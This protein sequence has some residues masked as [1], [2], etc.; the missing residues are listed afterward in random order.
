MGYTPK[1]LKE[2]LVNHS[3]WKRVKDE[4]WNIDHIFPVKAFIDYGIK[5]MSL[6]NCLENLQPLEKYD[7][8]SKGRK[9]DKKQFEKWLISKGQIFKIDA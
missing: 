8:L 4:V 5:D 7:N 2:H 1:D 3:N 9:Y 6:I